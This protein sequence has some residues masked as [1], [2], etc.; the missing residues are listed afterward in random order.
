MKKK[1]R[2]PLIISIVSGILLVISGTHGSAGIYGSLIHALASGIEDPIILK[3]SEVI[4]LLLFLLASL[5][6][7]SVIFGGY[8]IYRLKVRLGKFVIGIGTGIG[9]PGLLFSILISAISNNISE[10]VAQY[11]VVGWTG[12]L[13]SIIARLKSK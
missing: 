12:I 1:N 7:F 9:I 4:L 6:G 3:V 13:L 10:M 2:F 8:L 5:G 11:S